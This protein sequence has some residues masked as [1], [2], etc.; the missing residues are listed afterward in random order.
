MSPTPFSG[1][2][3][4]STAVDDMTTAVATRNASG[5]VKSMALN[6]MWPAYGARG[7]GSD[8]TEAINKWLADLKYDRSGYL[9]DR[10]FSVRNLVL[11]YSVDVAQADSGYPYGFRGPTIKGAGKRRSKI[12]QLSGTTGDVLTIKGKTGTEAGPGHNNKLAG[13]K[14]EG[15]E[16]RGAT[17]GGHGL[18]LRSLVDPHVSDVFVSGCGGS[19][20]YLARETFTS[21]VDDEYMYGLNFTQVKCVANGRYGFE[22][23]GTNSISGNFHSCDATAN[24]LGGALIAPTNLSMYGCGFIRNGQGNTAAYGLRIMRNTNTASTNNTMKLDGCRFESN[25]TTG[26]YDLKIDAGLGNTVD[27]CTFF[28][29]SGAHSIGIGTDAAGST[30]YVRGTVVTGGYFSGATTVA[31]QKAIVLGSDARE[32]LVLNPRIDYAL[33]NN[34]AGFTPNSVITDGGASTSVIHNQNILFAPEG[35]IRFTRELV[36]P[37]NAAAN[38]ARVYIKDN[39]AG[40]TQLAVRFATGVEQIIATEP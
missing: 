16:I 17:T 38:E 28:S 10:E 23:S 3:Y 14:L 1:E 39:G 40:K 22:C 15:F 2:A 5:E 18:H 24:S 34:G 19:G 29:T 13:L 21:G 35:F 20:V 32:T 12:S 9:P 7:D 37:G 36:T 6:P 25:S 27:G 8:D 30:Y 11:D 31:T 26:G 4:T 33:Y